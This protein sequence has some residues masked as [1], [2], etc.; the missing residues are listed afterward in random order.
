[1]NPDLEQSRIYNSAGTTLFRIQQ[2]RKQC[3]TKLIV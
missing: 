3:A 1:M 2:A